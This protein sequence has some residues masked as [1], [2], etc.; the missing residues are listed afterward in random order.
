MFSFVELFSVTSSNPET[1]AISWCKIRRKK[2]ESG[3]I[4]LKINILSRDNL[5]LGV[6]AESKNLNYNSRVIHIM[7]QNKRRKIPFIQTVPTNNKST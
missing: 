6:Y 1:E 7:L 4:N 3:K 5:R 2:R